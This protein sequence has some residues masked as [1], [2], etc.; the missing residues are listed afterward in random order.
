MP[1]L[2]RVPLPQHPSGHEPEC[3][4]ESC[5]ERRRTQTRD[6][7]HYCTKTGSVVEGM[8]VL[9]ARAIASIGAAPPFVGVASG[10]GEGG[11]LGVA[12]GEA[13]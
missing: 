9:L 10:S 6:C 12:A 13:G 2:R 4:A 7:T 1:S 3:R 11:S 8:N 5:Q